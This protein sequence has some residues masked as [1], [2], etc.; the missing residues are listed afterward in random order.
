ML[1]SVIQS[2]KLGC[3]CVT[4]RL[5]PVCGVYVADNMQALSSV[6]L[7]CYQAIKACTTITG[8]TSTTVCVQRQIVQLL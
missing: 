8:A 1:T 7:V 3:Y 2:V 6:C 4:Y 5:L